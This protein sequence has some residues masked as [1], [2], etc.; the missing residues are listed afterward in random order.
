MKR[1]TKMMERKSNIR[2]RTVVPSLGCSCNLIKEV[3]CYG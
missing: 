2:G 3:V 1:K